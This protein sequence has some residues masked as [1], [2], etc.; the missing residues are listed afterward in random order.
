MQTKYQNFKERQDSPSVSDETL[1]LCPFLWRSGPHQAGSI[2]KGP[3]WLSLCL[4]QGT[5][6]QFWLLL[7]SLLAAQMSMRRKPVFLGTHGSPSTFRTPIWS[8]EEQLLTLLLSPLDTQQS[9]S[10]LEGCLCCYPYSVGLWFSVWSP[11]LKL[12]NESLI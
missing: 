3:W 1:A 4:R 9:E 6:M 2:R 12:E 8:D 10:D 7:V 5:H 11:D